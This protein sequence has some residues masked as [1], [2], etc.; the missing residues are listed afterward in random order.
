VYDLHHTCDCSASLMRTCVTTCRWAPSTSH[1]S[2]VSTQA[3]FLSLSS[4]R[5]S[6]H[7]P[8]IMI[9]ATYT[10]GL[11]SPPHPSRFRSAT[12]LS[13]YLG[14]LHTDHLGPFFPNLTSNQTFSLRNYAEFCLSLY[15]LV[16]T[17]GDGTWE[18]CHS[19]KFCTAPRLVG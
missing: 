12:H 16:L 5:P 15:G 7:H 10:H 17:P 6:P 19:W 9:A 2:L 18:P 8:H 14:V 13:R 4:S 11:F 1:L 3:R